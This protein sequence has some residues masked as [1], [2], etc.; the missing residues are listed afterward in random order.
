MSEVSYNRNMY[1]EYGNKLTPFYEMVKRKRIGRHSTIC[2]LWN[3]PDS[4]SEHAHGSPCWNLDFEEQ[5]SN[6][7][8]QSAYASL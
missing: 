8:N 3:L 6:L 5:I 7:S 2:K 4:W 1:R